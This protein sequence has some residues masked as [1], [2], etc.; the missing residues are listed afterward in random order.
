M[1]S[2][3]GARTENGKVKRKPRYNIYCILTGERRMRRTLAVM[4]IGVLCLAIFVS[5]SASSIVATSQGLVA[6]SYASDPTFPWVGVGVR[7]YPDGSVQCVSCSDYVYVSHGWV[8]DNWSST[9]L[10]AQTAFLDP[11][12]NNFTLETNASGFTNPPLTQF[13]Y[14]NSTED[15]MS[16]FF[17]FQFHPG[18]LSSGAYSFTGTWQEA[19]AANYPNYTAVYAQRTITLVVN[20]SNSTTSVS[21]SPNPVSIDQPVNCTATVLGSSL[22]GNVTWS[23]SSSTGNFS[24]SVC[25][26]SSGNCSTTYVDSCPGSVTIAAWYSGDS[27]YLPSSASVTLTVTSSGPVYY[28]KNY[29]SVQAAIDNATAG[30]NVIVAAGTYHEYLVVDKT[31]TILG[32]RDDPVFGGGGS[33]ICITLLSAASG[34]IVTGIVI[35]NYDEGIVVVNAS[36]CKI[37][38]DIMSSMGDNGILL[39]GSGATGNVVY[40]NVFQDTPTAINLT[41]SAGGNTIYCNIISS[42]VTVTLNIGA[43]G[44][45]VYENIISG[46]SILLNMTDSLGT[47]IYRNDFLA[48]VQIIAAGANTW[49]SDYPSGGNY[50]SDYQTRYPTATQIDSSGIWNTAYVIDGNNKDNYPLMKPYALVVGHDIAVASVVTAKTVFMEGFTGNMTVN[51]VNKGEYNET[52]WVT[53]Y[54]TPIGTANP[55]VIG[56]QQVNNLNPT[57]QIA[58]TFTWNTNGFAKGNY[59]VSACAQAVQG[60]A[61]LADSSFTGGLVKV[62]IPGDANGDFRV[63]MD[64]VM[65]ELAAFGSTRRQPRYDANLDIDNN[66]RI[67]MDDIMVALANFGQHYP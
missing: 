11:T 51:A 38:S 13:I 25:T 1:A 48:T 15:S 49:D 2:S 30:S 8:A 55:M 5:S 53:V 33:G 7:L 37:Y 27:N 4:I 58:L 17:W 14:Y 36:N 18:D 24:Q 47:N 61:N 42:Q 22:T 44:N 31:L 63:T 32:E 59:A 41:S 19:A 9:P 26:L 3:L 54:A 62:T 20:L 52:F 66:G 29:S 6:K 56:S 21:L 43:N 12:Q 40:D 23:T 67:T 45:S 35:T 28:S 60:E 10:S 46:N 65:L 39:E 34:S 57:S 16:T 64:D 50:W